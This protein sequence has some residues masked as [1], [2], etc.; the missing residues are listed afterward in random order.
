MAMFLRAPEIPYYPL[1]CPNCRLFSKRQT[2]VQS[3]CKGFVTGDSMFGDMLGT[4][5]GESEGSC[6]KFQGQ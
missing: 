3:R 2:V 6:E 5:K 4:F 1:K